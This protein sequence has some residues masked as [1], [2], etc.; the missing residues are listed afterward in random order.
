MLVFLTHLP[1]NAPP[2]NDRLKFFFDFCHARG[3]KKSMF[4]KTVKNKF[5]N[6]PPTNTN[7]NCTI[8]GS[9][10]ESRSVFKTFFFTHEILT[11]PHLRSCLVFFSIMLL[12]VKVLFKTSHPRSRVPGPKSPWVRSPLHSP[13]SHPVLPFS[14]LLPENENA[15]FS[16]PGSKG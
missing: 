10:G 7:R 12:S 15:K 5:R 4:S 13:E 1:C 2:K 11:K 3:H 6:R 8:L 9:G 14:R 16:G